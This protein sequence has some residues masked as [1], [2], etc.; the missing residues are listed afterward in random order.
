MKCRYVCVMDVGPRS[1][2]EDCILIEHQV[3]QEDCLTNRS[4]YESDFIMMAVC[5]G[6]GGHD[7]GEEASRFVCEKLNTIIDLVEFSGKSLQTIMSVVQN[8]SC[9][10][11]PRGSGTTLAGLMV[12]DDRVIVFNAGDSRVYRIEGEMIDCVSRDHSLVQDLLDKGLISDEDAFHHPY[13]NVVNFGIGPA[14]VK[15]RSKYDLNIFE[16]K[17]SDS[18][19]YLICS[20]GVSDI[21]RNRDLREALGADPLAGADAL[22]DALKD[23]RLKDNTSFIIAQI[24]H[25]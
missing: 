20:D 1:E 17:I 3:Y 2:Q 18:A 5:D 10:C 11:L 12:K 22:M 23:I 16:E 19:L 8:S 15:A 24:S 14:F 9:H 13:K 7:A 25:S 4:D 6:M 21:I